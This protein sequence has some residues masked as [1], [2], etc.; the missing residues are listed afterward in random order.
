M[1]ALLRQG[2]LLL[3]CFVPTVFAQS[4][5]SLPLM[6]WPQQV[7]Q[8][9][10]GGELPLDRHLTIQVSGD[11]L[12]DAVTRWRARIARQTGWTLLPQAATLH[13]PTISV[14]VAQKVSAIPQ[15][16]S[17]ESYQLVI[18]GEGAR[19]EAATRFGAL[20]AMETLLQLINNGPHGT[21]LPWVTI[22]DYPRFPWRGVLLDSARHFLPVE[23]LK[24]Q[25]DGMAA[26]KLNVLHWHLVDDQG[27]RF[28]SRAFPQLTEKASDGEFY[29]AAQMRDVVDY[30]SARGIRVVPEIDMPGHA[31]ALAVAMPE[32]IS[33]PG[34][35]AME[36]G[37]GVFKPLMDPTKPQTWTFIE[38]ILSEVAEIFPDPWVHIG[39]D[40]VDDTQWKN[41]AT[42]QQFMQQNQLS[43]SHALQAYFNQRVEKI[44]AAHNKRMVGWDE[45]FHP[46]LPHSIL[47]QSWQGQDALGKV[48][49]ADYQGILSTG[50]YLDQPQPASY[51]Y[52]NEPLPQGLAGVDQIQPAEKAQSWQFTLPRLKGSAVKGSF[53]LVEGKKGWR[54]FIDFDGKA[55]RKVQNV[56]W[57]APDQI[58]FQVDTWMGPVRPVM[59]LSG[60]RMN[61]YMQ[62]GNVRYPAEGR[63]L[64]EVPEGIAPVIPNAQQEKNVLGGEIALWAEIINADVIDTRLWPRAFVVAERL[65]SARDITDE[66]NMYQRLAKIDAWSTLSAGVQPH[67][68]QMRQ[69]IRL[70]NRTEITSLMAFSEMLEPAQYYTRLHLKFQAGNYSLEEPLNRLVDVLPAE[71]MAIRQLNQAVDRLIAN[72]G[73][74]Q[75]AE[76]I[77][78]ALQR[79]QHGLPSVIPLLEQNAALKPLQPVAQHAGQLTTMGLALVDAI[80]KNRAFG[81]SDIAKMH[82]QIDEAA[83]L[84]DEVVLAIASP[85]EKLLHFS[86]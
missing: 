35:Y 82:T 29:T 37:W 45:I 16:D 47:I 31:S 84:Q 62:I 15:P 40:E 24:R 2:L 17:D 26:A 9:P 58:S 55:R 7:N 5:G 66:N 22:K 77:R 3:C 78:R 79:W 69:M 86:R 64:T 48:A 34:P 57:L 36:R 74:H 70:A 52:R 8:P 65:W 85:I 27:W 39:G 43:D 18:D 68:Q 80:E 12:E 1:L 75:A 56:Q 20:H 59:S 72:R 25:L 28:Q 71:S 49:Q 46:D 4:G 14:V 30:A 11:N 60:E 44:L 73:D 38:T 42:I 53:T 83:G 10:S 67:Q 63:R 21:T 6:P 41:A 51:H 81:A 61:G 50:F 76:T 13:S 23:T 33:A 32:L 54:G 19:I